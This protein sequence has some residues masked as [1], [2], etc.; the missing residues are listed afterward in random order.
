MAWLYVRADGSRLR[1]RLARHLPKL[2]KSRWGMTA[3]EGSYALG[4]RF[5]A[6]DGGIHFQV[7]QVVAMHSRE[8]ALCRANETV[9]ASL[10]PTLRLLKG[11]AHTDEIHRKRLKDGH[12]VGERAG[13]A[14]AIHHHMVDKQ[15][16]TCVSQ[17]GDGAVEPGEQLREKRLPGERACF[18]IAIWEHVL[19]GVN[20]HLE[21]GLVQRLL[22]DVRYA[23]L[24]GAG[25]AIEQNDG[26]RW[27]HEV[28]A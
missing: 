1:D 15:V 16:I 21:V 20:R 12:T 14:L 18:L 4:A 6:A 27:V 23:R 10:L 26:G 19:K 7:I 2:G 5:R 11:T 3:D 22:E 28:T 17:R 24:P 9:A 25:D 8:L 13:P